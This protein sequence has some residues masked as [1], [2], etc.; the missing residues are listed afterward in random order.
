MYS[1]S[2]QRVYSI[3]WP[4]FFLD[5]MAILQLVLGDVLQVTGVQCLG[6]FTFYDGLLLLTLLTLLLSCML[7]VNYLL[8]P[9]LCGS[10]PKY[11][12]NISM[13]GFIVLMMLAYP[14]VS[15]KTLSLFVC[16]D[17]DG[18]PYLEADYKIQCQGAEYEAYKAWAGL[19][20]ALIPVGW[21]TVMFIWLYR[22]RMDFEHPN[23]T[24]KA[25][26]GL[27]YRRYKRSYYYWE[28]CET[29]RK[30]LLTGIIV[31]CGRG[32]TLQLLFGQFVCFV[33]MG[34]HESV[35]PFDRSVDNMLQS[36]SLWATLL[37]MTA[38][39]AIRA[40][41]VSAGSQ[42]MLSPDLCCCST[43]LSL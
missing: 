14:I 39:I 36:C 38:G 3:P 16:R 29:V 18:V 22:H 25:R 43:L 20:I 13:Q 30:F 40:N 27:L 7:L 4:E 37:T 19:V 9:L 34:L 23:P 11:F 1:P 10:N 26:L 24:V 31:F 5:A 12:R 17:I 33:A 42:V 35:K 41:S 8:A 32:T 21:P 28:V 2:A 6:D 15:F